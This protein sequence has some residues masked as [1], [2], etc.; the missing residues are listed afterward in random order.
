[1]RG[2][3]VASTEMVTVG[4]AADQP[5]REKIKTKLKPTTLKVLESFMLGAPIVS[6]KLNPTASGI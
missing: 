2:A 5:G 1:L 6:M 4:A 3:E